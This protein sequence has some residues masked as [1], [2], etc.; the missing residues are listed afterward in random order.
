MECATK[1]LPGT[2]DTDFEECMQAIDCMMN[3]DLRG[4]PRKQ[5]K[6]RLRV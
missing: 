5:N 6:L 2:H 4:K 3:K 1:F